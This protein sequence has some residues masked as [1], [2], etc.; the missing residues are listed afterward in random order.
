MHSLAPSDQPEIAKRFE[1]T[2]Y[3]LGDHALRAWVGRGPRY[4]GVGVKQPPEQT[5]EIV[6]DK[7]DRKGVRDVEIA[8]R[9]VHP[10]EAD[11]APSVVTF[12]ST[13]APIRGTWT[14]GGLVADQLRRP[15]VLYPT[16]ASPLA[17][18]PMDR[19]GSFSDDPHYRYYGGNGSREFQHDS[20]LSDA[21][22]NVLAGVGKWS[23]WLSDG[24]SF[25]ERPVEITPGN[26][27]IEVVPTMMTEKCPVLY[28]TVTAKGK[29]VPWV[30][31]EWFPTEL[32]AKAV[33]KD[34]TRAPG[35]GI[36]C[37]GSDGR[38]EVIGMPPTRPIWIRLTDAKG[39]ASIFKIEGLAGGVAHERT[40]ELP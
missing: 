25:G 8:L 39:V 29:E 22:R 38:A 32:M 16:L 34:N 30:W 5:A 33:V 26:N 10:K 21:T 1:L 28:L 31:V 2:L 18:S 37:T 11:D 12:C 24:E 36:T 4:T 7:T 40:V 17:F 23:F 35:W 20:G 19:G 6:R 13:W 9:D 14:T 3:G 15:A 27:F